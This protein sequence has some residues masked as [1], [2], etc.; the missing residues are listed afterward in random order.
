MHISRLLA[1][2]AI[3]TAVCATA[4]ELDDAEDLLNEGNT[5]EA[6]E[7][8]EALIESRPDD[9]GAR[10]LKGVILTEQNKPEEAI[11]VFAALTDDHPEL[12]EPYNNLAVLYAGRGDYERA[13]AALQTAIRNN[14]R[15]ATAY[16]NLGDLYS[17]LAREA[18]GKAAEL[19]NGE[20]TAQSKRETLKQM[21]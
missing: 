19:D 6:L 3:L 11:E 13:R 7:R 4:A 17:Q 15:Y 2:L 20:G 18:Y 21:F 9:V 10:F 1:T 5:A 16:E 12:A 8:V 14:P